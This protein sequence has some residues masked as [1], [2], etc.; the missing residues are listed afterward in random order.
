M[1]ETEDVKLHESQ[2]PS[3]QTERED[4]FVKKRNSFCWKLPD[5]L[6]W[7]LVDDFFWQPL[8][9]LHHA[10]DGA[11][12]EG[13]EFPATRS[14]TETHWEFGQAPDWLTGRAP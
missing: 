5:D 11:F 14:R 9:D 7:Q 13:F 10:P 4:G 12:L 3:V 8:V 6:P 2:E 1:D